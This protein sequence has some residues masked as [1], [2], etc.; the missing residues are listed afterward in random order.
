MIG[1]DIIEL[2]RPKVH[3]K[4][5]VECA[6]DYS[7]KA[8]QR[9][10]RQSHF[11][12]SYDCQIDS[13]PPSILMIPAVS[14]IA[15][16]AW[17]LG[18]K[19]VVPELCAT[20]MAA[21]RNVHE[22][23]RSLYPGM[24]WNGSVEA[25]RVVDTA[26][27]CSVRNG[28]GMLFSGGVDAV[29]TFIAHQSEKP[30]LI[31]VLGADIPLEDQIACDTVC[32]QNSAFAQRQG[33]SARTVRSN[34]KDFYDR[35]YLMHK[36]RRHLN[37][38]T[39]YNAVQYGMGLLGLCAPISFI[40]DIRV[41]YM[42][43]SYTRE[44]LVPEGSHPDICNHVAWGRTRAIFD[45]EQWTRQDKIQ[46][47]AKH[48]DNTGETFPIR[49]CLSSSSS[50]A[51]CSRCEKCLRTIT[52]LMIAGVDPSRCGFNYDPERTPQHI[53]DV[54]DA[55]RLPIGNKVVFW[56]DMQGKIPLQSVSESRSL[57][58]FFMW[59]EDLDID[60]LARRNPNEHPVRN[61]LRRILLSLTS[62]MSAKSRERLFSYVRCWLQR[63]NKVVH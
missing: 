50:G 58:E 25:E 52:G 51:N 1:C 43:S 34:L 31:T 59:F 62:C 3:D 39:W 63:G 18:L 5:S 23:F 47:I 29:A 40:E 15:P 48:I 55:G 27:V 13:V 54:I 37:G 4:V 33:V 2:G 20:F 24:P 44:Q 8:A 49:V 7:T 60:T 26:N 16:I 6:I 41:I 12:A 46:E 53:R 14:N 17:A 11:F 10:F 22:S 19:L 32:K 30:T 56:Q 28:A 42:A 36:F 9:V 21:M 45:G 38:R 35:D 57:Q 61:T